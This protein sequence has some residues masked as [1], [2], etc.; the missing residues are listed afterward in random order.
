MFFYK[1]ML[2]KV[3]PINHVDH[4]CFTDSCWTTGYCVIDGSESDDRYIKGLGG[5]YYERDGFH[6]DYYTNELIYY[7]NYQ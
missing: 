7:D 2:T 1:E 4:I 6:G 3:P 5:P